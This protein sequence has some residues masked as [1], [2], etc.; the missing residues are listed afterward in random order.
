MSTLLCLL[1]MIKYILTMFVTYKYYNIWENTE[2]GLPFTE[3]V[4][5]SLL[6][7]IQINNN[8]VGIYKLP[9]INKSSVT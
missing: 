1:L 9:L 4:E 6:C 5:F 8:K 2:L 3:T 7:L